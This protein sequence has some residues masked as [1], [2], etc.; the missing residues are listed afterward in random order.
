MAN[1]KNTQMTGDEMPST[2]IY[3]ISKSSS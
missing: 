2:L 3:I 1:L